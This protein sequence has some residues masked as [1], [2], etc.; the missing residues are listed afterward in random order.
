MSYG[1]DY[2]YSILSNDTNVT[3]LVGTFTAG[4][5]TYPAI[6]NARLIPQTDDNTETINFYRSSNFNAALNYF[7]TTWSI[8]CR[9]K[10]EY[11]AYE[12]ADAVK[13]AL[14]RKSA[15]AGGYK[16]F[17]TISILQAIPPADD[18]DVYNVPVEI[19]LRRK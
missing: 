1:G 15:E 9:A 4:E 11:E 18:A 2:I 8:D 17:G 13:D 6:Y 10:S 19:N 14:N 12:I 3:D 5:T 16:Y 7:E